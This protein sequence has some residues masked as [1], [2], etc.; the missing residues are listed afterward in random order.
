MN[1]ATVTEKAPPRQQD[2]EEQVRSFLLFFDREV[3]GEYR[4]AMER[5]PHLV[6]TESRVTHFLRKERGDP[7]LAAKRIALYW[8]IRKQWFG[9]DRWLLN[10]DQTGNGCLHFDDIAL[11]R[12]G[13]MTWIS[14]EFLENSLPKKA[15]DPA[16][17]KHCIVILIDR[18]RLPGHANTASM[19]ASIARIIFYTITIFKPADYMVIQVAHRNC[20]GDVWFFDPE[21]SA[22]LDS[23]THSDRRGVFVV[24]AY[25]TPEKRQYV[26]RFARDSLENLT[27][28]FQD[29][30][31]SYVA[32]ESSKATRD[33]LVAQGV[34]RAALPRSLGGWYDYKLHDEWIRCRLSVEDIMSAANL[35]NN[36]KLAIASLTLSVLPAAVP[37]NV[38]SSSSLSKSSTEEQHLRQR[39][40]E[41]TEAFHRR[42]NLEYSRRFHERRRQSEADLM[43]QRSRLRTRNEA[44]RRDNERLEKMYA[45]ATSIMENYVNGRQDDTAIDL[46]LVNEPD[47]KK[48][49]KPAPLIA[50]EDLLRLIQRLTEPLQLPPYGLNGYNPQ[51]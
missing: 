11:L 32:E 28:T 1:S 39:P 4:T 42:R 19:N 45:M 47:E 50:D 2:L 3:A 43:E 7:M 5:V 33:A 21:K 25:E 22:V 9:E 34:P 46:L 12:T 27:R 18:S 31:I 26:D 41:S 13:F 40:G 30:S 24:R 48:S 10:M 36:S 51:K 38:S 6:D 35:V 37:R 44:L 20:I 14:S 17:K 15:A 49:S 16:Q 8:K 29:M 23:V